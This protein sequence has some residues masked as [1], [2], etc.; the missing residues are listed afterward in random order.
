MS[1]GLQMSA[2][3]SYHPKSGRSHQHH[4]SLLG[5]GNTTISLISKS[6]QKKQENSN[7]KERA[8]SDHNLVAPIR[9]TASIFKQ[10]VTVYKEHKSRVKNDLKLVNREKP[11]QLFWT[12]RL[13]N[14]SPSSYAQENEEDI[15][16][17]IDE[18]ESDDEIKV[19]EQHPAAAA[20]I[21]AR[22][23]TAVGPGITETM[24]LAS[25]STH[26]HLSKDPACGQK[27]SIAGLEKNPTAFINPNQPLMS[28]MTVNDDDILAA[29]QR[30]RQARI[31][32]AQAI[33]SLG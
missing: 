25:I 11:A 32:L 31:K 28:N 12:R 27:E 3:A 26:L 24:L 18:E 33:K 21:V 22:S 29:E 19:V 9:Q 6:K 10:P 20:A 8:S 23:M 2:A 30:V 4:P 7:I 15:T 17:D 16:D 14:L 5:K 13:G 1:S